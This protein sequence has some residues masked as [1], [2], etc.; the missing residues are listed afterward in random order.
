[1][2]LGRPASTTGMALSQRHSGS[3]CASSLGRRL[4]SPSS[5]V[6]RGRLVGR[7]AITTPDIGLT[8]T[9]NFGSSAAIA[10]PGT[11]PV[12]GSRISH[13]AEAFRPSP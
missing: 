6:S 13:T 12:E 5:A 7:A 4:R 1:M 8:V 10:G 9:G 11:T 3:S 2:G